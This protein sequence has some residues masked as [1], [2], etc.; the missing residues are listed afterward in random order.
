MVNLM[1]N[2][3]WEVVITYLYVDQGDLV[4][5]QDYMVDLDSQD[6]AELDKA[7][8]Y[9]SSLTPKQLETFCVGEQE[10]M[11]RMTTE[12]GDDAKWARNIVEEIFMNIGD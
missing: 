2:P 12:G 1:K 5:P 4:I 6:F 7:E 11:E 8:L 3:I 10:D 9:L